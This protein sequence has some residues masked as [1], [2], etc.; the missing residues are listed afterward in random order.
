MQQLLSRPALHGFGVVKVRRHPLGLAATSPAQGL[1]STV[2]S[3]GSSAA[4]MLL[5]AGAVTGP[6]GIAIA[7]VSAAIVALAPLIA[8]VINGCGESCEVTTTWANQA[9]SVLQQNIA[10]YFSLPTPRSTVDQAQALSNFDSIWAALEQNCNN[11]SL[12]SPGQRCITD[13]QAGACTWHQSASTVPPWGTPPAG[14]CWNWFNGYR[15]PIANDPDVYTP[16]STA[17]SSG[18]GSV[19]SPL[20]SSA[21]SADVSS[22]TSSSYFVPGLIAA[23]ILLFAVSGGL[24]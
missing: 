12:G 6:V 21:I 1:I 9:E 2:G 23:G 22:I 13:R 10:T 24:D 5:A 19:A 17:V 18:D 14:A 15:D 7:G 16:S 8:G 11:P 20:S 3:T 4:T